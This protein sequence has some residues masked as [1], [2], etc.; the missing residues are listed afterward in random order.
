MSTR[1][2]L[3]PLSL[4][5]LFAS[6]CSDKGSGGDTQPNAAQ[7]DAPAAP[8]PEVAVAE[9]TATSPEAPVIEA[10]P[11]EQPGSP[12][13][14]PSTPTP[15]PAEVAPPPAAP[16]EPGVVPTSTVTPVEFA[17]TWRQLPAPSEAL[18]FVVLDSGVLAS[19][20]SGYYDLDDSGQLTL[21]TEIEDWPTYADLI[22]SWPADVWYI[23]VREGG[24]DDDRGDTWD[25]L[26]LMRLRNNKR[27]VPQEFRGEQRFTEEMHEFQKGSKGGLLVSYD[28]SVTRVAGGADDPSF[29][30]YAGD[31]LAYAETRSGRIYTISRRDDAVWVQ[32]DCADEACVT[33]NALQLPLGTRWEF[34]RQIP[35][36]RHSVSIA[37]TAKTDAGDTHH[38]LHYGAGGWKLET[39]ASAP[40]GLWASKDGGL[41]AKLGGDLLHRD[42][43]GAWRKVS[44]PAGIGSYTV[45]LRDDAN[46]VW[47]TGTSG[48]KPVLYAIHANVQ[49]PAP[50]TVEP[51]PSEAPTQAG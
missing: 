18:T 48:G 29:G 17:A 8:A 15:A 34:G 46:E 26:R 2:T 16:A 36:Q 24:S 12:A 4:C 7:P 49:D 3:L 39:L 20:A 35:R 5:L 22:G 11:A 38:L 13:A 50:A 45:A 10:P 37:A 33:E 43:D 27:W 21:R 9:P 41:W 40:E 31:L 44:L 23:E 6:A 19:S 51:S 1:R 32:K 14:E 25:E 47:L 30:E 42:P 28:G